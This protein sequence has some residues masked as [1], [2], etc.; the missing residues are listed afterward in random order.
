MLSAPPPLL[1]VL[2]M[3]CRP[4]WRHQ[5]FEQEL[6]RLLRIR[7]PVRHVRIDVRWPLDPVRIPGRRTAEHERTHALAMFDP[8][9]L[10]D[11]P[12]H[13]DAV[14]VRTFNP[15]VVEQRDGVVGEAA[16]RIGRLS[17]L[18][19]LAS[20]AVVERNHAVLCCKVL[21]HEIPAMVVAALPG[22]EQ[23]RLTGTDLFVVERN[24]REP[25]DRHSR[26]LPAQ[27]LPWQQDDHD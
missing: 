14:G 6:E 16:R 27:P 4:L 25:G 18:F 2:R 5:L 11:A 8:E 3:G 10:A 22:N 17:R 24:L 12:T 15:Q 20:T 1:D 9:P 21:P 26:T 7:R 13:G 23:Q 19:A